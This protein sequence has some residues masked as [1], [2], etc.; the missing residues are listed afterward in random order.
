MARKDNMA[1]ILVTDELRKLIA[2]HKLYGTEYTAK[3]IANY[4]IDEVEQT[5]EE[6][7]K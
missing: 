5:Y 3:E 4:I 2:E 7:E 6:L 1:D